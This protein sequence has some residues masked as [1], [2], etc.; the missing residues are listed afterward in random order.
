MYLEDDPKAILSWMDILTLGCIILAV[1]SIV[2]YVGICL[3]D[4]LN[5]V[6]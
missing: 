5:P 6:M 2:G 4:L 3:L 1:I